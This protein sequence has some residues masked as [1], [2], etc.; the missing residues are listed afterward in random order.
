MLTFFLQN[1]K[2]I[3]NEKQ[4][5]ADS[6]LA[7]RLECCLCRVRDAKLRECEQEAFGKAKELLGT[8]FGSLELTKVRKTN[9]I[10]F[11]AS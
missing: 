3:K 4:K 10:C 5:L 6:Y 1:T 9:K 11:I 8:N 2:E 7:R